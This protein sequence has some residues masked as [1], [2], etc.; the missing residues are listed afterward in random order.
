MHLRNINAPSE[1]ILQQCASV[2]DTKYYYMYMILNLSKD[3]SYFLIGNLGEEK[4]K[5]S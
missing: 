2:L 4:E 3:F 5:K 1:L